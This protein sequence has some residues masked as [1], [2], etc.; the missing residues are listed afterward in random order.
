MRVLITAI[1]L[2]LA[3]AAAGADLDALAKTAAGSATTPTAQVRSV[4]D[5][6]NHAL[7]WTATD[8][9][10]RTAEEIVDRKG[11][12]C[13]EQAVVVRA[14]LDRLG[15]KT[16]RVRE[17]NI[18]PESAERQKS[19]EGRI[20]I[21]G[22]G[23]SVFGLRHN[24]HVWIEYY[25][26]AGNE[27]LPADPTLNL[28]GR[29]EW[30]RARAGFGVRHTAAMET[31]RDMLVP[32]AIFALES[33]GG[34]EDRTNHYL[35]DGLNDIYGGRLAGLDAWAEWVRLLHEVNGAAHDAFLGKA[36]LHTKTQTIEQLRLAYERLRRSEGKTRA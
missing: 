33:D 34:L 28:V 32:I 8:Y 16:R 24:D 29:E 10:K 36:N 19:A 35:V 12:N 1:S 4:I 15:V 3:T 26:A 13:N 23:A 17:I 18:Q 27:W 5:W 31:S 11:G 7:E 2:L 30:L 25:D 9:Q 14:L 20:A 6:T 22:V 21:S